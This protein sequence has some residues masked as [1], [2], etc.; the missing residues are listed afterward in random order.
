MMMIDL[1]QYVGLHL[2]K[3]GQQLKVLICLNGA[4]LKTS[5]KL[6]TLH[7]ISYYVIYTIVQQD[8]SIV[9][10]P[11]CSKDEKVIPAKPL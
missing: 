9:L 8:S 3:F 2:N 1:W 11:G 4:H 6:F 7:I 5:S 10:V